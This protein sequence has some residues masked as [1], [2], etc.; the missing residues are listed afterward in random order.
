MR[1]IERHIGPMPDREAEGKRKWAV[2]TFP[3]LI[4]DMISRLHPMARLG[5]C[6]VG[7]HDG[8]NAYYER[9][10][11][12]SHAPMFIIEEQVSREYGASEISFM[13]TVEGPQSIKRTIVSHKPKVYGH[14]DAGSRMLS[15]EEIQNLLSVMMVPEIYDV[16]S[17]PKGLIDI[18]PNERA[19]LEARELYLSEPVLKAPQ[20]IME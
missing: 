6:N 8:F 10:L 3:Q 11:R 2:R 17:L 20:P 16:D 18:N 1:R 9:D 12:G 7:H 4:D 5:Q 19:L 13:F 15:G 14:N